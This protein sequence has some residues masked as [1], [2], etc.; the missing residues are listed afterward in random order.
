MKLLRPAGGA[1]REWVDFAKGAAILMVVY[2]HTSLY[3][4]DIGVENTLGRIKI[5]FELFPM[6]LFF[7]VSG[8]FGSRITT[9]SFRD[10]WRRRLYPLLWLYVVWSVLRMAFY[11]IVPL[12]NGGLG[13]LPATDPLNL[14][15]L[16]FWPSSSY[17][18]IYGLFLFTLGAWLLRRVDHRVQVALAAIV[19]TLFTTGLVN[20]TNVGWNR[21][22]ALFVFFLVGTLYSKKIIQFVEQKGTRAF[23]FVTPVFVLLSAVLFLFP[24]R[25]VPFLALAGQ[26]SAVAMGILVSRL[27]SRVRFLG[28]F[29][30][31]GERS[32]HIYLLHLYVIVACITV[33]RVILPEDR[34]VI[35]GFEIPLLLV[36]MALAVVVSLVV[37]R[38]LSK[39]RWIYVPPAALGGPGAKRRKPVAV[40]ARGAGVTADPAAVPADEPGTSP[41]YD[42]KK[43]EPHE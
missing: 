13:E 12:A 23:L 29:T 40:P 20:T 4:G 42:E 10:L 31:C 41:R 34:S 21:I 25:W 17:W 27:L 32:L 24:V 18:F 11:L 26:M 16:F 39:I 5:V 35:G 28:F 3:L 22:G 15:L 2:Y 30:V 6:P 38:Y 7:L 19:G 36:V 9:W 43:A 14:L 1:R 33:L 37:T 8:L